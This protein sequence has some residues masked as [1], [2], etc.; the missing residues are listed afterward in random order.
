MSLTAAF[1]ASQ[2]PLAPN[3]ITLTDT[4]SGAD[5]S[6][7]SR[8]VYI[9]DASGNYI[10]PL[11]T[12]TNYVVWPIANVS[13]SIN[14]LT[15]DLAANVLVQ[16]LTGSTVTY[17]SNS[18]YCF[19]EYNKQFFYYLIQQQGLIPGIRQDANYDSNSALLW[20]SI[21]GA[22]SA[23]ET[24]N[25]IAASTNCLNIANNLRLNQSKFF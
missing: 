11:G 21:R 18:N 24:G 13:I 10:V 20:T 16:W 6:L 2:T 22:I 15:T 3:I 4:S 8:R 19:A 23:V 5:G 14:C 12:T 1:S 17:S 25:D 9:Q 7:T